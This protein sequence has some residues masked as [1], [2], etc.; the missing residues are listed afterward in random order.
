MIKSMTGYGRG[1]IEENGRS[2]TVEIKSVNNRYLD[3]NIRLPRQINVLEDNIRKSISSKINRGKIDVYITQD[4]F[5]DEDLVIEVDEQLAKAYYNSFVL[6]KEKF[7]LIDDI[8]VSLLSKSPDVIKVEKKEEDIEKVWNTLNGAL[9]NALNMLIDMRTNEGLK[10]S[11]DIIERS[12]YIK[13]CVGKIEERSYIVVDDYRAKVRQRVEEYL[14]DVEIDE[15]RLLNEVAFFSDKVN[16][17]EEI[18]RLNSHIDQ[19]INTL[20]SSEPV[21]RKLDFLMQEMNRE[22]N[23]IGSKTNDLSIT[24]FVVEIKSELEKIREQIQNIE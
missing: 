2:F 24:N 15:A 16:I 22:A 20:N 9:D 8:S 11:K 19:L 23:T 18:V 7:N 5:S 12:N 3:I 21:G 17:T 6:L 4:K 14:K 13:E 10:L 1:S